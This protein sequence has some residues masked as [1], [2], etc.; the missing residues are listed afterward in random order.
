[1]EL[2]S[3]ESRV[4]LPPQLTRKEAA[5]F[6]AQVKAEQA[7]G[8]TDFIIDA[9]DMAFIDSTGI[10]IL[11]ESLK[12]VRKAGGDMVLAGLHGS[13]LNLFRTTSLDRLFNLQDGDRVQKAAEE[14]FSS[15]VDIRL[16]LQ[17]EPRNEI[18]I[19]HLSGL[20]NPPDGTRHF[21]EQMLLAMAHHQDFVLE[22]TRLTYLDS[23]A[24][25]EVVTLSHILRSSGG[26]MCACSANALVSDLFR[27]LNL[28][29]LIPMYESLEQ[30]LAGR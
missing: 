9:A 28:H 20:M 13:A 10:G 4:C 23:M 11:V 16:N 15:A 3:N 8:K 24:I 26:T 25:S 30:A 12:L 22:M 17:F 21:K 6:I 5:E 14:L 29:T 18:C 2:R 19:V 7:K 27:C 1:M